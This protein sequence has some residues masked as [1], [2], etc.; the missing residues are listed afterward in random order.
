MVLTG[1]SHWVKTYE[2][3]VEFDKVDGEELH[4]VGG[5]ICAPPPKVPIFVFVKS[6]DVVFICVWIFI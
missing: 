5:V 1:L 4:W 2:V 3:T 6:Q